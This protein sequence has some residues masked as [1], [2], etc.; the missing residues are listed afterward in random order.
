MQCRRGKGD[1]Q[2]QG[3]SR[4]CKEGRTEPQQGMLQ[5]SPQSRAGHTA[6]VVAAGESLGTKA[7]PAPKHLGLKHSGNTE[8][9]F[10]SWVY[11]SDQAG[12]IGKSNIHSRRQELI[13][14]TAPPP[15]KHQSLK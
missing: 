6:A 2:S 12:G 15:I 1:P 11:T 13:A 3:S 14:T 5:K 7:L 9:L 10:F 4:G 8:H